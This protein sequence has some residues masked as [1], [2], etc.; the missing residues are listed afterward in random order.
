M[1]ISVIIP[2]WNRA[3]LVQRA[4][5]S[6]L[7]QTREP[8]EVIVVD[9]GSDDDTRERLAADFPQARVLAQ[10]NKGVSAARNHGIKK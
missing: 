8:K 3:D 2:T 9:D 1:E 5:S 10:S 6:A 7:N 4:V